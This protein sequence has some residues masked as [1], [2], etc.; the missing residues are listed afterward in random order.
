MSNYTTYKTAVEWLGNSIILQNNIVDI[1]ES[2]YENMHFD[3]SAT[4]IYQWFITD[5]S[6]HDVK[7]LED[8]FG[9]LFSYSNLLDQYVL[10]VDHFGTAWS[11]V[12]CRVFDNK[13]WKHNSKEYSYKTLTGYAA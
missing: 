11:H 5:F 1:D 3:D 8:T 6:E 4:E 9:L 2:V 7:W 13:W 12:P 10:C